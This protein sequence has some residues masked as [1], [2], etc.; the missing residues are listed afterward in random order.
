MFA[1]VALLAPALPPAS[2]AYLN[3]THRA[4]H[5]GDVGREYP[6]AER[7]HPEADNRQEPD[8]TAGDERAADG[9]PPD[10]RPRQPLL[11]RGGLPRRRNSSSTRVEPRGFAY[12]SAR[13]CLH[14]V[15]LAPDSG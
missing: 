15:Q 6:D 14:R 7:E 8:Q 9:D 5:G 1:L 10:L 4:A 13:P 11:G 3:I 12:G 2:V